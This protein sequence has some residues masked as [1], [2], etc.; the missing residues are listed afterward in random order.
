MGIGEITALTVATLAPYLT[1]AGEEV[2]KGIGKDLWEKI[3]KPFIK[4]SQKKALKTLEEKPN[5]A[6]VQGKFEGL[7]EMELEDNPEFLEEI[8]TL[9]GQIPSEKQ[10]Q[11]I[12]TNTINIGKGSNNQIYQGINNSN[13]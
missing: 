6:K 11:I 9:L 13:L 12:Q 2:S 3:K 7:L 10:S 4:D 5:D 8:K 1:K